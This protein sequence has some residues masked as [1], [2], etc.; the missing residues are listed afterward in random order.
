L[1]RTVAKLAQRGGSP[2]DPDQI[3]SS[4]G[5]RSIQTTERHLGVEQALIDSPCD[6]LGIKVTL[7]G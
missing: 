2:I 5:H 6:H 7:D 3:Q 4:L 1:R